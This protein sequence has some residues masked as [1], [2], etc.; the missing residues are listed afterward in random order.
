MGARIDNL[1]KFTDSY[2]FSCCALANISKWN[3][4]TSEDASKVVKIGK[5]ITTEIVTALLIPV[6]II[7][8]LAQIILSLLVKT[9]FFFIP[10]NKA[11]WVD[12]HIYLPTISGTLFSFSSIPI[13]AVKLINNVVNSPQMDQVLDKILR[14]I[15]NKTELF[16]PFMAAH[17]DTICASKQKV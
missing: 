17:I 7:E 3:D 11:E 8:T 14:E 12:E 1:M 6:A 15:F 5:L 2:S 13:S 10:E 4:N 16:E 9:V